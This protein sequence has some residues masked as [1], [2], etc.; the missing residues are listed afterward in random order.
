MSKRSNP[1]L[2]GAFVVGAVSLIVIAVALLGGAEY[3]SKRLEY[4]AYFDE[5]TKGLRVGSN[6]ILNGVRV[7]YVSDIALL[8]D[9][10]T[11]QTLTQVTMEILPEDLIMTDFGEVIY[12]EARR[13][14]IGHDDLVNEAGI[15]A[16]LETESFVTGTLVVKLDMRP[17]TRAVYRGYNPPHPEIPTIPSNVQALLAKLRGWTE[18]IGQD[19]DFE[20]SADR[21]SNIL[22]GLEELTNSDDLRQFLAG[23]NQIVNDEDAKAMAASVNQTLQEIRETTA[24]ARTLIQ[25]TDDHIGTITADLRPVMAELADTMEEAEQTLAAARE[26]LS[27]KSVQMYQLQATLA[28][29]ESA[30]LALRQFF[31]YLERNPEALL[32][33]KE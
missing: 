24:Q 15:R 5:S 20:K 21:I 16:Q 19:F 33:G 3:F 2:I 12:T 29:V 17:G 11:Y 7:G 1:A 6:V 22:V 28:E 27:G 18:K 14:P 8:V 9:Q 30:A 31:D 10:S 13:K 23:I 26:Q 32:R 25:N 4:V